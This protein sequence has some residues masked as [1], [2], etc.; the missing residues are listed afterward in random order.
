MM[1][2]EQMRVLAWERLM[3]HYPADG[4]D[5]AAQ[6][7]ADHERLVL[8]AEADLDRSHPGWYE[9]Y[10]EYGTHRRRSAPSFVD[11]PASDPGEAPGTLSEHLFHSRDV[12]RA[13]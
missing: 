4:W 13:G 7:I 12:E 5:G 6:L 10:L 8:A 3:E 2:D 11:E 1:R 9:R